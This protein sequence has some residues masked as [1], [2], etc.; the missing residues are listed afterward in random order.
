MSSRIQCTLPYACAARARREGGAAAR[1]CMPR[2][3]R[4]P[5]SEGGTWKFSE[6]ARADVRPR[7]C[8]RA[9]GFR[10]SWAEIQTLSAC[11]AAPKPPLPPETHFLRRLPRHVQVSHGWFAGLRVGRYGGGCQSVAL[12]RSVIGRLLDRLHVPASGLPGLPPSRATSLAAT[13]RW[14]R[15]RCYMYVCWWLRMRPWLG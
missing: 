3:P 7:P 8:A 13:P 1:R 5:A 12:P 6:S 4:Q 10:A 14:H 2:R 9:A 11:A 15:W